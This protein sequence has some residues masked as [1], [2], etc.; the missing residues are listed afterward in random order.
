MV[1]SSRTAWPHRTQPLKRSEKNADFFPGS[2]LRSPDASA[3]SW[4][5]HFGNSLPHARYRNQ[6]R[7]AQL[8]RRNFDSPISAGCAPGPYVRIERDHARP[9]GISPDFRI[10][11]SSITKRVPRSL[12]RSSLIR[13]PGTTLSVGDRAERASGAIVSAN[14]FD[15]L[16]V[17]PDSRARLQA[18]G[19]SRSQRASSD[20]DRLSDLEGSLRRRS[21]HHRPNAISQRGSA[22]DH[23]RRAG[24][25]SRHLHRI[26]LQF[27]GA[28]LD[29]G[30]VRHTGYKLEDRSCALD[31]RLRISQTWRNA[32]AGGRRASRNFA[33]AGKG[34]SGNKS[35]SRPLAR[36]RCGERR[37]IRRAT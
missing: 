7:G 13:S 9:G 14:Y 31:R 35:R 25:I 2:S 34:L 29:A 36:R 26:F 4:I 5:F 16:G 19:R 22:H 11:N 28:D 37:S 32:S 23:R 10:P 8:D 1:A 3:Q 24:K 30:D 20:G 33:T 6:C 18:G 12:S 21:E 17:K 27:L 15:A